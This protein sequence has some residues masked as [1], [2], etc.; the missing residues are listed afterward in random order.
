MDNSEIYHAGELEVQERAGVRTQAD[1]MSDMILPFIPPAAGRFVAA[2]R[3]A[4][5]ASVAGDGSVWCSA[6]IG[7]PGFL[8]L[9]DE[10]TLQISLPPNED[11]I[12]ENLPANPHAGVIILDP[13]SRKRLR[14]NGLA[15]I[16]SNGLSIQTEQAYTNCAKYIQKRTPAPFEVRAVERQSMRSTELN[17][18]QQKWI[19]AADTF[20]IATFYPKSGADA[21]HR[22]GMPGFVNV[23]S[24][25]Q[26][27]WP[28]Y[29]G[30]NMFQSLGNLAVDSKAGLLFADFENGR[31]LQLSG[32]AEILW[33]KEK[34]LR[35]P[36]AKRLLRLHVKEVIATEGAFSQR[37]QLIEYSPA[38]PRD[39][40]RPN[41]P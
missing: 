5:V 21:S 23:L 15:R 2:Q 16:T 28:D 13:A 4:V 32:E 39:D 12:W 3:L 30:N 41:T 10:H 9:A 33:D 34:A 8:S 11:P 40:T 19:H 31:T 1:Q 35:F 29:S 38:N 27:E 26:L 14:V 36:G 17:S 18:S 24:T 25:R 22:G 20:F 7:E 37:W 6:M